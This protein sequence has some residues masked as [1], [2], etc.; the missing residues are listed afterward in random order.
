MVTSTVSSRPTPYKPPA[1]RPVILSKDSPRCMACGKGFTTHS[2]TKN[3]FVQC[4]LWDRA[5]M[6]PRYPA[7]DSVKVKQPVVVMQN[8]SSTE[9]EDL[10]SK[11]PPCPVPQDDE[12]QPRPPAFSADLGHLDQNIHADGDKDSGISG[13]NNEDSSDSDSEIEFLTTSDLSK[14][15]APNGILN[16]S[17]KK[18]S[19][20]PVSNKRKRHDSGSSAILGGLSR[21]SS[22]M[23]GRV[24]VKDTESMPAPK[25]AKKKTKPGPKS[26][27]ISSSPSLPLAAKRIKTES[28]PI[29]GPRSR[30]A[31]VGG[32]G[33]VVVV[34]GS[35]ARSASPGKKML[36]N[37]SPCKIVVKDFYGKTSPAVTTPTK[38]PAKK[39][40]GG[41]GSILNFFSRR[42]K[43]PEKQAQKPKSK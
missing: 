17:S 3:H 11:L 37:M 36:T 39:P 4:K 27:K 18:L 7:P 23:S 8:L 15:L 5:A 38:V 2:A 34:G 26:K 25:S 43:S 19:P 31:S 28:P 22:A 1:N 41:S 35:R 33:N 9:I 12:E 32:G 30:T 10:K 16:N 20:P 14:A 29:K 6:A 21:S 13:G 42:P 24:V 40:V